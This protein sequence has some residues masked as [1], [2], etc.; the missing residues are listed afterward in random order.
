MY[1]DLGILTID[2]FLL[3]CVPL[4]TKSLWERGKGTQTAWYLCSTKWLSLHKAVLPF[5]TDMLGWE[6]AWQSHAP[7][8]GSHET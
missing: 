6:Y 5:A 4:A 7:S 3:S 2:F 8:G 1:L